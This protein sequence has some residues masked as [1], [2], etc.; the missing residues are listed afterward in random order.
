MARQKVEDNLFYLIFRHV[1]TQATV[2]AVI[3]C[4][5]LLR[6]LLP[7]L[8]HGSLWAQMGV[9]YAPWLTFLLAV[10]ALSAEV[11][12]YRRHQLL[13]RQSD[14]ETLRGLARLSSRQQ[15]DDF[16]HKRGKRDWTRIKTNRHNNSYPTASHALLVRDVLTHHQK[17]VELRF[18]KRQQ[19]AADNA[20]P[21]HLIRCFD[22]VT[23]QM[24]A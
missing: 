16:R 11:D 23:N 14:L 20:I 18:G 15:G 6:W 22:L 5:V 2:A 13:K 19:L 12:K 4:Y 17:H 1:P 24:P 9:A 10:I 8:M 7:L 3:G 21:A